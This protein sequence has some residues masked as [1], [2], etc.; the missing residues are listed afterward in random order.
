MDTINKGASY[1]VL[2][3]LNSLLLCIRKIWVP[4]EDVVLSRRRDLPSH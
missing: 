3:L 4:G 1:Y 2:R